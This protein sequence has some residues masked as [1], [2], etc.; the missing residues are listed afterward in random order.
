MIRV[1][2]VHV[3]NDSFFGFSKCLAP[4][5]LSTGSPVDSCRLYSVEFLQDLSTET[6]H[7]SPSRVAK[8]RNAILN[9]MFQL[10]EFTR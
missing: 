2:S 8:N 1:K 3:K 7:R 9:T 4:R 6:Q 10:E 5:K